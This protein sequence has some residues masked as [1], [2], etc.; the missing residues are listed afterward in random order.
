MDGLSEC[1]THMILH[2]GQ[3]AKSDMQ[4]D[5]GADVAYTDAMSKVED[6]PLTPD[7]K[8]ALDDISFTT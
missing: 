3:G 5:S 4:V 2:L 1:K 6:L 7:Q 8:L